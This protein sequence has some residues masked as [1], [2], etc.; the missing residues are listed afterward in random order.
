MQR[1]VWRMKI[2]TKEILRNPEPSGDNK[3]ST[4]GLA[5]GQKH[6]LPYHYDFRLELTAISGLY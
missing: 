2:S 6:M 4:E 1:S 3:G 5:C